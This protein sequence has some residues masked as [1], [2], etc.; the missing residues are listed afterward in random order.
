MLTRI[1]NDDIQPVSHLFDLLHSLLVALL[2]VGSQLNDMDVGIL[3]RDLVES[4]RGRRVSCTGKDDG[5]RVSLD[6]ALDEVEAN[7]SVCARDWRARR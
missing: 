1:R 2:V 7:A 6:E 3:A 4:R 5:L